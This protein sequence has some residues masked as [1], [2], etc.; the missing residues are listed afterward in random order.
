M[1][2]TIIAI[3][4]LCFSFFF[5]NAQK[6]VSYN[7]RNYIIDKPFEYNYYGNSIFKDKDIG[8]LMSLYC[9]SDTLGVNF[10]EVL[11]P[12]K[13]QNDPIIQLY[14]TRLLNDKLVSNDDFLEYKSYWKTMFDRPNFKYIAN[15]ILTDSLVFCKNTFQD[16]SISSW[17]LIDE[18]YNY[19]SLFSKINDTI[20]K[21]KPIIVIS[22][23]ILIKQTIVFIRLSK[24]YI[25]FSDIKTIETR[26]KQ[27]INDFISKNK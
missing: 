21:S 26:S 23:F 12:E 1:P 14:T 7:N 20:G 19:L 22:N 6:K 9:L 10:L 2:K 24:E 18:D 4:C 13:I 16:N 17:S 11:V 27:I 25:S 5:A 3:L 15:V 8:E